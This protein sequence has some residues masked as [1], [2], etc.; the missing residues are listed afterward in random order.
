MLKFN[1]RLVLVLSLTGLTSLF[2]DAQA[3]Q[4]SSQLPPSPTNFFRTQAIRRLPPRVGVTNTLPNS[5]LRPSG[6]NTLASN[7]TGAAAPAA[8]NN[9]AAGPKIVFQ[10][11][12]HDFGRVKS[13]DPV[14]YTYIFTNIGNQVLDISNV[15]PQCGCTTAGDFSHKVEPGQ[16]GEIPIQFNTVNYGSQV[17]KTITVASN[18]KSQPV[19]VLQLK[20]TVWK[21]IELTPPYTIMNILPDTPNP[22]AVVRILTNMDQPLDLSDPV[23]SNPAFTASL[24]TDTPGKE[25]HL[26]LTPVPPLS[27]GTIQGKVTL[28]TSITNPPTVDVPFWANVQSPVMVLPAQIMIPAILTTKVTPSVTIQNNSTN[29]LVLSDPEV[30]VP[31]AEVHIRELQPGRIFSVQVTLP[32]GFEIPRGQRAL[33][34]VKTSHPKFQTLQ[35]PIIQMPKP[36]GPYQASPQR[37]FAPK[38]G[39]KRPLLKSQVPAQLLPARSEVSPSTNQAGLHASQ[40]GDKNSLP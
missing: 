14:K 34:T 12:I 8:A 36:F 1:C 39:M 10:T 22:K 37:A 28:K 2:A 9:A 25:Y 31:G 7:P 16:T 24:K 5:V 35:V 21:P 26:T 38:P 27:P 40:T 6:P 23:S 33:L 20:G 11:P 3:L 13:G 4:P 29:A 32:A 18:D 30:S 15:H 17:I 19:V